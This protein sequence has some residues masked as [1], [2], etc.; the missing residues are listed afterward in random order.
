MEIA[1]DS[2][3]MPGGDGISRSHVEVPVGKLD[4]S[5]CSAPLQLGFF[6]DGTQN[7]KDRDRGKYSH[8]NVVRLYDIYPEQKGGGIYR[9][10]IPG[11]GT[12][13][14]EIGDV[15]ESAMGSAFGIGCE[16][17]VLYALLRV[18]NLLH[19]SAFN[20][21]FW[22]ASE[23]KE[24]CK[25]PS[26]FAW[27]SDEKK[28]LHDSDGGVAFLVSKVGMLKS[29]LDATK[30]RRISECVVDVFGFSRGAAE[31]RVFCSWL[32]K[33]VQDNSFAGIPIR[34]RFLGIFDTVAAAG[35]WSGVGNPRTTG[36]H[37]GWATAESLRIPNL[38][39]NCAHFMAMHELRKNFPLDQI[40]ADGKLRK[41][42]VE[43]AFP[44][45]HSDVGGGYAVGE[46]GISTPPA[47]MQNESLKLS[48]IPLNHMLKCAI[49]AGVPLTKEI[50]SD[51]GGSPYQFEI[52]PKVK[53]AFE[54]FL[55]ESG[56]APRSLREWMQPYLNWRWQVRRNFAE[57]KQMKSANDYD[58]RL[59]GRCNTKLVQDAAAI[60]EQGDV[61]RSTQY[62]TSVISRKA[63]AESD[64]HFRSRETKIMHFDKEAATVLAAAR[65]APKVSPL[66]ADF[67]DSFVHDSYAGFSRSVEEITGYWRYRKIFSGDSK[68]NF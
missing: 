18:I 30:N 51:Q 31:A 36:G 27:D 45:S 34:I 15:D 1:C 21:P 60:L 52:S 38:V 10:Y 24:L 14:P 9:T 65:S 42:F 6:F 8:S 56:P 43:V 35:F 64:R 32:A 57:T 58:K 20:R 68:P 17:R 54:G 37:S 67:F 39:E 33:L 47:S 7:N 66:L 48:Q 5:N 23:V 40:T 16:A 29:A 62:V 13:F 19:R 2:K 28:S 26:L 44:G 3:V 59:L 61:E 11:V 4:P 41:G 12:I 46:L 63:I 25:A 22:S 49:A 55:R 50:S 53:E